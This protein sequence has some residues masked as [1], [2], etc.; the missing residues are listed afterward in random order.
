QPDEEVQVGEVLAVITP[1]GAMQAPASQEKVIE[2]TENSSSMAHYFSQAVIRLALENGVTMEELHKIQGTGAS[3]RVSK[4]DVERYLAKRRNL[5]QALSAGESV[6]KVKM[7]TMRK[8]I[9]ENMVK[10]FYAAPHASLITEVDVTPIVRYLEE[11]KESFFKKHG[12]K[13]TLTS[14]LAQGLC[15]AALE[16]PMINASLEEDMIVMKRFVNLGIAVS[17]D[18]GI[19]VPVIKNCHQKTLADIAKALSEL[20]SKAKMAELQVADTK[21]GTI[22]MTNFGMTGTLIG[23]P[24]IRYPEVAIVGIGAVTKKVVVLEKDMLGI[25]SMLHISLTFDHRII[26]GIYGCNFLSSLKRHLETTEFS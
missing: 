24:I 17:V 7:S 10:S 5:E 8:A 23:I 21:E 4:Q 25:R 11:E 16:Y 20:A 14:F 6:E 2:P 15:K 1:T 18:Q 3:Q 26:D 19:L 9:A 13:L 22:T 12:Y